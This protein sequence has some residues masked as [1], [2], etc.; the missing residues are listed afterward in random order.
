MKTSKVENLDL[1]NGFLLSKKFEIVGQLGRGW[2]GEVYFI[3]E[4][5]TGIE[6]AAKIFYPQRNI[7]NVAA[8]FYARKL[9]K[10]RNCSIL[11]KYLFQDQI[12][13]RGHNLT[14]L[15]S[16]YVE[17]ETLENFLKRQKGHRLHPFQAVHLLHVLA[18]GIEE[19]HRLKEYHGDLHTGNIILQRYGL[20]FHVKL[21]DLFHMGKATPTNIKYD[22]CDLIR[23]FYE[24]IGGNKYYQKQPIAVKEICCG[25]K[26]SLIL[27][28]FKTAGQLKA[29][30][31][32][33]EWE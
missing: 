7:N 14:Y 24:C 33:M 10:L 19:I 5:S 32:N 26:N 13:F 12:R 1:P 31:E 9:H 30:L 25:L 22:V 8:K 3:R 28:K 2:E 4:V 21:V 27:K 18:S 17:G 11:I 16:D 15:I 23:V 6:R 29:Y 20:T